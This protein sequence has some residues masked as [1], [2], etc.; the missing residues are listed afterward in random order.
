MTEVAKRQREVESFSQGLTA[1]KKQKQDE[2][3]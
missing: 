3:I 2:S 1:E